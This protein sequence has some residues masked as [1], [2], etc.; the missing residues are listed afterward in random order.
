MPSRVACIRIRNWVS[1]KN[2]LL[3]V[4]VKHKLIVEVEWGLSHADNVDVDAEW[5]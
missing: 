1:V 3:E 4:T 5:K 2:I